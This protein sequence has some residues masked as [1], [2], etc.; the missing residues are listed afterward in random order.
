MEVLSQFGP[1]PTVIAVTNAAALLILAIGRVVRYF[2]DYGL[3]RRALKKKK[4]R[5]AL[6]AVAEVFE[7]QERKRQPSRRK[8]K[9]SGRGVRH[10]QRPALPSGSSAS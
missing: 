5:K 1:W 10:D 9:K 4:P 3:T 8:K 7:A 6:R 2:L